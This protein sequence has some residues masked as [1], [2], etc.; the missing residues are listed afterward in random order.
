[1]SEIKSQ[2]VDISKINFSSTVFPTAADQTLWSSLSD[3]QR[4]AIIERDEEA[5]F[6]SG[7]APPE[8]KEEI[9][10]RVRAEKLFWSDYWLLNV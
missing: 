2:F 6:H 3:K 1:M 5:A 8:T 9:L 10:A 4:L 7:V